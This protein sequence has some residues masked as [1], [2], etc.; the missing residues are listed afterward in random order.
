MAGSDPQRD[1]PE[2]LR[3]RAEELWRQRAVD[4]QGAPTTGAQLQEALN[5]LHELEVHQIEL[6]MQN[7]ELRRAQEEIVASRARYFDLYELAPVGYLTLD[8][9]GLILQANLT[10]ANLLGV[11]RSQMTNRPLFRFIVPGDQDIYYLLRKRLVA[12]GQPQVCELRMVR[13]RPTP[14]AAPAVGTA[15]ASE[16]LPARPGDAME[17]SAQG[18]RHDEPLWVRLQA[19]VAQTGADTPVWRVTLSDIT[20]RQW[21]QEA[22]QRAYESLDRRV[23]ERTVELSAANE[24]LRLSHDELQSLN[25]RLVQAQEN[26]RAAIARELHDGAGQAMTVLSMGL[27][28]LARKVKDPPEVAAQI[29]RLQAAAEG[30]ASEL[31]NLAA[32]L[33]PDSL[34]RL[35]LVS[36]VR[37]HLSKLQTAKGP[38][39]QL[40]AAHFG[41]DR[42]PA[43]VELAVYR[44]IQEAVN[45]ALRHAHASFIKVIMQIH[46]G[47][48]VVSIADDG[49]GFDPTVPA[50]GR[51]GLLT[52]NE[53]ITMLGGSSTITSAPGAGTTVRVEA[54][55]QL[56]P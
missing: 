6:E 33:H 44:V 42:L 1:S 19:L 26:E 56:A 31:H 3:Q 34:T 40:E 22:L 25:H 28:V 20:E 46:L 24:A 43:E 16:K 38:E 14:A 18:A 48:L 4:R 49:N 32:N 15:K 41:G 47:Q 53:R 30:L 55:L 35:G 36:A 23:Q 39:L 50:T 5:L 17:E 2:G 8:E 13:G 7:E 11:E 21:A 45:N 54:P 52:M 10:A 29:V 37:E 27:H 51:L 9:T 12:T